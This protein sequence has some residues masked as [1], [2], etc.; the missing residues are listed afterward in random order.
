MTKRDITKKVVGLVSSHAAG[1]ATARVIVANAPTNGGPY[2]KACVF[3]GAVVI[4][5]FAGDRIEQYTDEK[6]DS[7]CD[8]FNEARNAT[9]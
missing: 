5:S 8:A 7:I 6:I 9:S 2:E 1:F 4:G 3:I